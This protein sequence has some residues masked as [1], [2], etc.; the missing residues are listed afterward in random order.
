MEDLRKGD[1]LDGALE[2]TCAVI[3]GVPAGAGDAPTPCSDWPVRR[4]LGHMT[5][6]LNGF[7]ETLRTGSLELDPESFTPG[8]D[9]AA[10]YRAA[11]DRLLETWRASDPDAAVRLFGSPL[12]VKFLYPMALGEVVVHG[13]DLA[14]ATGRPAP[15]SAEQAEFVLAGLRPMMKPEYRGPDKAM[16][17]EVP[18]PEDA[19][20]IDRLVGFTGR[21]PNWR[22][23]T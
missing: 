21:D 15:W 20:A 1:L 10:E 13:W 3:A 18:V 19:P 2:A 12:P 22:P 5:G 14:T 17:A 7:E 9:P 11:G 16:G 8:D 23:P 4:L 6:W